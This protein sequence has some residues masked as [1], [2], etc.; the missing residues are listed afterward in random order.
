MP[1]LACNADYRCNIC[2][3]V[4]DQADEPDTKDCG[5]DCLRCM[6]EVAEDPDCQRQRRNLN[7]VR[8]RAEDDPASA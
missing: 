6:S 8:R 2:G 3:C 5:G 4:L 7:E 1:S